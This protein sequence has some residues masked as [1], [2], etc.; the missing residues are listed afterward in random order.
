MAIYTGTA[1]ADTLI[2]GSN[3]IDTLIGGDGN[4]ALLARRLEN[5]ADGTPRDF[6]SWSNYI[7]PPPGSPGYNSSFALDGGNGNDFFG[8]AIGVDNLTTLDGGAGTDVILGAVFP[9]AD[10]PVNLDLD[11]LSADLSSLGSTFNNISN[12]EAIF[13]AVT[14][15]NSPD[16]FYSDNVLLMDKKRFIA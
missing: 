6:I 3:V 13:S 4:D 2:G 15:N 7:F 9:N 14:Y 1:N 11:N 16:R 10:T 12:V 5:I 8:V